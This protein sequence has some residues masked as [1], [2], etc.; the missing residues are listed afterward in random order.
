[1]MMKILQLNCVFK[2][3]STGKIVFDLHRQYQ[4]LGHESYVIYG[5]GQKE[6][7]SSVYKCAYELPSKCRNFL[8]R[9]TGNLYGSGKLATYKIIR[10]I[11]KI[12]PDIVHVHCLNGF[13]ADLYKLLQFLRN[14][15]IATV[16]T[17]H[18]EFMY[19]GNCGYAFECD[20]WKRQGC[21]QCANT[22]AAIGSYN[23]NAPAKNFRKMKQAFCGFDD[24]LT[25]A[26]VSNWV[27]GRAAESLILKGKKITTVLNG[28]DDSVFSYK[29]I[30]HPIVEKYHKQ[31][32]KVVLHVTP[33]FEDDNKGGKYVLALAE[34]L[35]NEPIQIIVVGKTQKEY[36]LENITF[37]GHT[38][39]ADELANLY[40]SADLCLLTS[41]KETFSMVCAESLCCGTRIV[42]FC[43]GAPE[44]IALPEY[45]RF[46]TYGDIELLKDTVL[47]TLK[48]EV[49]KKTIS[50][51]ACR[52]YSYKEMAKNY[53]DVYED[54][55]QRM[56]KR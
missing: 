33:L 24:N 2:K 9:F 7:V 16:I 52:V 39:N 8:A 55:Q 36:A 15:N 51:Q 20:Q 47:Q 50:Q 29:E 18:A 49:D 44:T 54:L 1:M 6:N 40:S 5:R 12:Q 37:W 34:S 11:R 41:K 19:T 10:C 53:L 38:A 25:I 17:Q 35:E 30:T 3:G 26:G 14:E 43:A 22:L 56:G 32:K 31:N 23:H 21:Q 4:A 13:C 28:L 48:Q 45:S 46:V 27:S 42:G